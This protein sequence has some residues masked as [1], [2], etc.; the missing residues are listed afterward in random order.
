MLKGR[1]QSDTY[2]A[3]ICRHHWSAQMMMK[4]II[5]WSFQPAQWLKAPF[6]YL[7]HHHLCTPA[8]S[9]NSWHTFKDCFLIV[10]HGLTMRKQSLKAL[11]I[12]SIK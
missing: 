11:P 5:T 7:F 12:Y 2:L 9:T 8:M 1:K 3:T 10:G 6:Y 4:K